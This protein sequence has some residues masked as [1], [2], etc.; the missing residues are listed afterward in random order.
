MLKNIIISLQL[1]GGPDVCFT[2][3]NWLRLRK[4]LTEAMTYSPPATGSRAA[5]TNYCEVEG[6]LSHE[7]V[8]S[9]RWSIVDN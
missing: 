9:G 5:M 3:Q 4:L 2:K 1:R 6:A 7:K 8:I